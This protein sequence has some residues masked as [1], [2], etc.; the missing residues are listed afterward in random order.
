VDLENIVQD[1]DDKIRDQEYI[2]PREPA[3]RH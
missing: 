3:A 2:P 1:Y